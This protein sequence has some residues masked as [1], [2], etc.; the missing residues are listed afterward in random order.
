M[1]LCFGIGCRS[2]SFM[3]SKAMNFKIM[4]LLADMFLAI[5]RK[6]ASREN[7]TRREIKR[8]E[9]ET[10]IIYIFIRPLRSSSISAPSTP[11]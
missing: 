6:Y 3:V 10:D 2:F 8:Q 11:E 9:P 5:Q 4:K 1:E 7:Q